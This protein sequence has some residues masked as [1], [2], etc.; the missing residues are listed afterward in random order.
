MLT[1]HSAANLAEACQRGQLVYLLQ[2][3][4]VTLHVVMSLVW[5]VVK[6]WQQGGAGSSWPCVW[7]G[8]CSADCRNALATDNH[9]GSL[10]PVTAVHVSSG[11]SGQHTLSLQSRAGFRA[12]L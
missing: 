3:L 10:S 1:Y 9:M 6:R 11:K 12:E 5:H 7:E 4:D 8:G 2:P